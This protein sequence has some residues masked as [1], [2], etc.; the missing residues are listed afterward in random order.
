M[1][2]MFYF[3]LVKVGVGLPFHSTCRSLLTRLLHSE[4]QTQPSSL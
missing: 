1:G 4:L 2:L 3:D